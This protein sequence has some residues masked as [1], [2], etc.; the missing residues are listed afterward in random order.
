M[1]APTQEILEA[2]RLELENGATIKQV[3][4]TPRTKEGD[5]L[6]YS[7]FWLYVNRFKVAGTDLDFAGEVT[8]DKIVERRNDGY[9]WG[10]I[11]IQANVPE[12]RVRKLFAEAT[13]V[14]SEGL[15]TGQ[16]GRFLRD[17]QVFYT[18]GDRRVAGTA[19]PVEKPVAQT[20]EELLAELKKASAAA[21]AKADKAEARKAAAAAKKAAKANAQA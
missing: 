9:S 21:K 18:G 1:K 6:T 4:A 2:A 17:D 11:A 10:E 15:R 13:G 12:S 5:T 19:I 7:Q 20:R 8:G 3:L 16:G 14:R